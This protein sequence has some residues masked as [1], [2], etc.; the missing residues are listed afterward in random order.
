MCVLFE[1][2]IRSPSQCP[3]TARSSIAAGRSLMVKQ[4]SQVLVG[5]PVL[6][7]RA[8]GESVTKEK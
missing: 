6:V 8:L 5:G 3:G 7:E 2:E 4:T 1:P